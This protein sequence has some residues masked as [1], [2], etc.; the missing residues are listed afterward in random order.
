MVINQLFLD[1][2]RLLFYNFE[3]SLIHIYLW[4]ENCS[5]YFEPG[6]EWWGA[7]LWTILIQEKKEIVIIA[8]SSTD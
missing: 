8:A 2:N 7:Y 5:R 4:D 1:L 3:Y 6:K